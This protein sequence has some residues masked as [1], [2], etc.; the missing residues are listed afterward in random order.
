MKKW[1]GDRKRRGP[2]A[3]SA[4]A[5]QEQ[6][7]LQPQD[8]EVFVE[9]EMAPVH[10][11]DSK[12]ADEP[13][14]EAGMPSKESPKSPRPRARRRKK[15]PAGAPALPRSVPEPLM[16]AYTE[17]EGPR[18]TSPVRVAPGAP[19]GEAAELDEP[20]E[21]PVDAMPEAVLEPMPEPVPEPLLVPPP[22]A[23]AAA[24]SA[25]TAQAPAKR[26]SK[27]AVI[28]SVG[29][30]GSGK[31]TWFKRKGVTPL[32]SDLLRTLL[33]D[34]AT[35]QRHQD[36]V[37]SS[38]RYLLRTRM[39]A[40]M[41]MNYVDATNLSPKERRHW[42]RMAKEFGYEA[43]AV[44]F[45]VPLETCLER[46]HKRQRVVPEDVMQ[47]MSAKLRPPTFEEGFTKIVVVRVKH[48]PQP[49][50]EQPFAATE[51]DSMTDAAPEA[52]IEQQGREEEQGF[53]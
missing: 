23:V 5:E 30:P 31:T 2:Q 43:H 52:E 7:P 27:G 35:E 29:L 36:L 42:I 47:R 1:R 40:R 6:K 26:S 25:P 20:V 14:E 53:E 16:P 38:L 45:D 17:T 34:D 21:S 37:F 46:N 50:G 22:S 9:P 18:P 28:L 3:P 13:L 48:R 4:P 32:S 10:V 8:S 39:M 44:Y 11:A 41:P 19:T 15:K 12:S 24:V 49:E 33:F 51:R